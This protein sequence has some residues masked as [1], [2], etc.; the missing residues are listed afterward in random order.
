MSIHEAYLLVG[1]EILAPIVTQNG[2]K[3]KQRSA[4]GEIKGADLENGRPEL[5]I[6]AALCTRSFLD[7][8]IQVR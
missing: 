5:N 7:M 1:V 2:Q 4:D 6:S 3:R 8:Q